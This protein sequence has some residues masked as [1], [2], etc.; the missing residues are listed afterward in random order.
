MIPKETGFMRDDG[1][2]LSAAGLSVEES[3]PEFS[4]LRLSGASQELI[5]KLSVAFATPWP[6]AP[7]KLAAGV[8]RL[9]PQEWAII[10]GSPDAIDARVAASC[11]G[12]LYH[13]THFLGGKRCWR[14]A[15]DGAPDLLSRGAQLDFHP[16]AFRA[17]AVALTLFARIG[18]L[19]AR[20][21]NESAYD[22]YADA[23]YT[24]YIRSWLAA[25]F[26]LTAED[27]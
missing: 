13:L 22:I 4:I 19:I 27:A 25:A 7:N 9:S 18:A 24:E 5:E 20:P 12:K 15:G 16:S 21:G 8:C 10:G 17:G 2:S 3:T 26:R 6:S 1:F 14:V 23:S 11:R